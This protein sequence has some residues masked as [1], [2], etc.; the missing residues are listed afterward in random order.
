MRDISEVIAHFRLRI[1]VSS[2]WDR[3]MLRTHVVAGLSVKISSLPSDYS[4]LGYW[5]VMTSAPQRIGDRKVY[6]QRR[7]AKTISEKGLK[8]TVSVK[9]RLTLSDDEEYS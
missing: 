8:A 5:V 9:G 7:Q 4:Q 6:P 2:R 3:L 1:L